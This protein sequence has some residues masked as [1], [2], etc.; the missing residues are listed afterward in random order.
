M[1]RISKRVWLLLIPMLC[2][3][4]SAMRCQ[5]ASPSANEQSVSDAA[6]TPF[7][8]KTSSRLVLVD[9]VATNGKGEPVTDLK[10][11][12]FVVSED[13][14]PQVVHNFSFQ[15]PAAIASTP[16]IAEQ[17]LQPPQSGVVSNIPHAR[18]GAIWNVIVLDALNSPLLELSNTQDQLLQV[19][20]K[21]PDQPVAIYVLGR[22][23]RLI[24][25]FRSDPK[26]L[27]QVLAQLKNKPSALLDNPKGG[28]E[29]ERIPPALWDVLPPSAQAGILRSETAASASHMRNRLDLTLDALK[30]IAQSLKPLPGRKNL[31]WISE[32]FPSALNR[33]PQSGP[34][35]ALPAE[36]TPWPWHPPRT[37][38]L[39]RRLQFTPSIHGANSTPAFLTR[40]QGAATP[41]A[42]LILL[43]DLNQRSVKRT[44][45][46]T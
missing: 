4:F 25:D 3:T 36:I 10:A 31:I 23:L 24:Q 37:H 11:E 12:D 45:T 30:A 41:S 18:K 33:E 16:E 22:E 44:I 34:A 40:L 46:W 43:W 35:T 1:Q 2:G 7:T 28:H 13:G 39:I 17:K 9:V 6:K 15:Q 20:A 27:K 19:L 38:Y 32:A 29:G 42:D 5:S 21:L 14:R 26:A 8:L